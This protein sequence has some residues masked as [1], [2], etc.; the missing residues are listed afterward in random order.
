MQDKIGLGVKI[1]G[2]LAVLLLDVSVFKKHLFDNN[3]SWNGAA[4]PVKIPDHTEV[5][6][7]RRIS[8]DG[9]HDERD[10]VCEPIFQEK[11]E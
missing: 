1:S 8:T 7:N 5:R 3:P 9:E 10:V 2:K 11:R 6:S 4:M